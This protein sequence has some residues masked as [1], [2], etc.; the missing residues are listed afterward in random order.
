MEKKQVVHKNF[1]SILILGNSGVG[2]TLLLKRIVEG[3]ANLHDFHTS[4]TIGIDFAKVHYDLGMGGS[5]EVRFIDVPGTASA[6][7]LV[8]SYYRGVD[9]I[10]AVYDIT[11]PATLRALH[12]DWFPTANNYVGQ[13]SLPVLVLANKKDLYTKGEV[14]LRKLINE[15]DRKLSVRFPDKLVYEELVA[16]SAKEYSFLEN[17]DSID[18]FIRK[19]IK[20]RLDQKGDLDANRITLFS[21]DFV[22]DG[23]GDD[24]SS[25]GC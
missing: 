3:G 16:A 11:T 12:E 21:R 24:S 25:C 9:A 2:K 13:S 18:A 19:V 7:N 14:P 23:K 1:A 10:I 6:R 8:D 20:S 22:D 4:V 17:E 15:H 5:Y